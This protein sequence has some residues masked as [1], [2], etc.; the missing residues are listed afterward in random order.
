MCESVTGQNYVLVMRVKIKKLSHSNCRQEVLL[1]YYILCLILF[2]YIIYRCHL[3][4]F[5]KK[6]P[7]QSNHM[8]IPINPS[9]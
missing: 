7:I 6:K 9:D 3:K 8:S 4:E 5:Y 2:I 1:E